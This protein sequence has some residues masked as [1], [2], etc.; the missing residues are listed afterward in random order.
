MRLAVLALS[1]SVL[2]WSGI[3]RAAESTAVQCAEQ[4]ERAQRVR[5][6][7]K[8][9]EARSL[10]LSCA[11]ER[12]PSI[13][14]KDCT[15]WYVEIDA[16]L[17]TV[18]FSAKDASGR[19]L[20]D[21]AVFVDGNPLVKTL[22]AA[23]MPLDPGEHVFRFEAPGLPPAE[24]KLL[25]RD[26]E[27]RRLVSVVLEPLAVEKEKPTKPV[28]P[29]SE[30]PVPWLSLG[31]GGVAAAG[32]GTFAYFFAS[33]ADRRDDLARTCAPACDEADVDS[34][35]TQLVV[36]HVALGV[37]ITAAVGAIV[38]YVLAPKQTTTPTEALLSR[39]I[40]F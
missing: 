3:A 26:G 8:L 11:A 33:A 27:K 28:A 4:S 1:L 32:A 29:A 15:T 36:A 25:L 14:S 13:V 20:T 21:V 9:V 6:E 40:R 2:G 10:F 18:V 12:C 5:D 19:D 34:A 17:P 7:G 37:G 24:R 22:D 16:R 38:A 35:R 31:L 23:A 30:R 39:T